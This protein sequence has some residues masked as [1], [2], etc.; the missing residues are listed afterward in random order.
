MN[1]N[2]GLIKLVGD[3]KSDLLLGMHIVA[4]QAESLIGEGVMALRDGRDDR[5]YRTFGIRIRPSPKGS[6]TPPKPRTARRS[7]CQS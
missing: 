2:E 7:T 4:P 1:E 3:A 5:G 6:W